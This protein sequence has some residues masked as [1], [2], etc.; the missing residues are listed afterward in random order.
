M[1]ADQ[2]YISAGA[3][4]VRAEMA[5]EQ[6]VYAREPGIVLFAHE[7]RESLVLLVYMESAR[8]Q[9][10]SPAYIARETS[11]TA[12]QAHGVLLFF[13]PRT[14]NIQLSHAFCK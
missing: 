12:I 9:L 10:F 7:T 11:M 1:R 6:E 14:F 13:A 8:M 4:C 2:F 3:L 5:S